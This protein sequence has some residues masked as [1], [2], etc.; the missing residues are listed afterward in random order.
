MSAEFVVI[1]VSGEL[2]QQLRDA[3]DDLD[4]TVARGVTHIRVQ[5][6][7]PSMLHGVLHRMEALGLELLDVRRAD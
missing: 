4:V 2:D 1:T 7:D 6:S 3:F 5:G